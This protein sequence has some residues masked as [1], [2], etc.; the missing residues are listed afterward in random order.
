MNVA[1]FAYSSDNLAYLVWGAHQAV[2][3]DPGAVDGMMDFAEERGVTITIVTNTHSHYDHVSGNGEMLK[4]SGARFFSWDFLRNQEYIEIDREKLLIFQTPGHMDDC[5]S[6]KADNCLITGD[7]LFN[8]TV[9][10][11]FSGDMEGFFRSIKL[12]T[13][14]PKDSLIYAGHDYVRE[15]MAF[16]MTID[17]DNPE[18]DLFLAKYNANHVVSTLEDEF[19]VNPYLRF[20]HPRFVAA[21]AG[22]GL[23]VETEYERWCS[24]ME[25]Y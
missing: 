6:F 1:Q 13:S 5:L 3:I 20:N 22:K 10:N 16:A 11:C 7:T 17:P 8:G 4:R 12:L 15:S 9:G 23:P 2:A 18:I 25:L 24:M 21:M 19:K 14:F